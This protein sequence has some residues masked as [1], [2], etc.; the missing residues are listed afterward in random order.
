M[1]SYRILKMLLHCLLT[2]L[3][4]CFVLTRNL[5]YP[6]LWSPELRLFACFSDFFKESLSLILRNLI[7]MCFVWFSCMRFSS[8]FS[9]L[10]LW[11]YSFHQFEKISDICS[12]HIFVS[13]LFFPLGTPRT[14]ILG[15]IKLAQNS[16]MLY[17]FF[18]MYILLVFHF[19]KSLFL[20]TPSSLI[21]SFSISTCC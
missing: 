3:F 6:H 21:F 15:C 1:F 11:I 20:K 18:K 19:R 5:L 9:C 12:L 17:S 2:C 10:D 14:C 16:L 8:C 7:I 13:S 4:F